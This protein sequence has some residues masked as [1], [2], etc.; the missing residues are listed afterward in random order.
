[1]VWERIQP[2]SAW[3]GPLNDRLLLA[4][5]DR[6][7]VLLSCPH[8]PQPNFFLQHEAAF[9]HQ[10]LLDDR[11][12]RRITLLSNRRNGIDWPTDGNAFDFDPFAA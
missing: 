8:A 10:D 5:R 3:L 2:P 7:T 12:N 1:M 11:D 4:Q 6:L 9:D